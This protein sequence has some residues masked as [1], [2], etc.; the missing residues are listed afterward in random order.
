MEATTNEAVNPG[1]IKQLA[2]RAFATE[3]K[4]I[5][6]RFDKIDL[7]DV[8]ATS[9]GF[10]VTIFYY[11]TPEQKKEVMAINETAVFTIPYDQFEAE[12][13]QFNLGQTLRKFLPDTEFRAI[14]IAMHGDWRKSR[15]S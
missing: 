14:D 6:D 5:T 11:E 3:L 15:G 8:V 13:D 7:H 4:T 2:A 1:S 10:K 9:D 12:W